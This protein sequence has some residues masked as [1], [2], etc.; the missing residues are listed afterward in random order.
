MFVGYGVIAPEHGWDDYKGIDV[1]SPP[2]TNILFMQR[3]PLAN[4]VNGFSNFTP[5]G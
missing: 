2:D 4:Y 3:E 1:R 5:V